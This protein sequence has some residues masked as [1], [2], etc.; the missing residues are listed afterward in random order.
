MLRLLLAAAAAAL[1][2][3]PAIA[4]ERVTRPLQVEAVLTED[5]GPDQTHSS[6]STV[7]W[8]SGFDTNGWPVIVADAEFPGVALHLLITRNS[9]ERL[10]AFAV[11]DFTFTLAAD[12]P[13]KSVARLAGVLGRKGDETVGKQF[14]GGSAKIEDNVFLY[15]LSNAKADAAHNDA[16]LLNSQF[17][18]IAFVYDD[19]RRAI[20]NLGLDAPTQAFVGA[21]VAMW[22]QSAP[23]QRP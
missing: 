12:H 4:Q 19:K 10:P 14:Q 8:S 17:F 6:E 2:L 1:F 15:A 23:P 3:A 5:S 16:L 7:L 9:D 20:I 18:D 22:K 13:G 21:I 11:L